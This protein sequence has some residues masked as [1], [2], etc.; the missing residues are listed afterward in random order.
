MHPLS[1]NIKCKFTIPFYSIKELSVVHDMRSL[2]KTIIILFFLL[3]YYFAFSQS[4]INHF[5]HFT[6]DHGLPQN[7]V[8]SMCFDQ[9][10]KII[11]QTEGGVATYDGK[12]IK[13]LHI[14]KKSPRN[15]N[16]VKIGSEVYIIDHGQHLYSI[17]NDSLKNEG[18]TIVNYGAYNSYSLESAIKRYSINKINKLENRLDY[19]YHF[20][21]ISDSLKYTKTNMGIIGFSESHVYSIDNTGTLSII[22]R[23]EWPNNK[24]KRNIITRGNFFFDEKYSFVIIDSSIYNISHSHDGIVFDKI[25]IELPNEI[26]KNTITTAIFEDITQ[27]FFIGTLSNGFYAIKKPH[28]TS[29]QTSN[30]YLERNIFYSQVYHN[31]HIYTANGTIF[32]LS[33]FKILEAKK[34]ISSFSSIY[35]DF[36]NNIWQTNDSKLSITKDNKVIKKFEHYIGAKI[37]H[38]IRQDSTLFIANGNKFHNFTYDSSN[39]ELNEEFDY[40]FD[41]SQTIEQMYLLGDSIYI[42]TQKGMYIYDRI[43]SSIRVSELPEK[44]Y[45]GIYPSSKGIEYVTTYGD[46]LYVKQDNI[47][48]PLPFD[49]AKYMDY[50]HYIIADTLGYLWIPTNN[51]LYQVMEREVEDY[52]VGKIKNITY[53]YYDKTYGLPRNEFNGGIQNCGIQ[54][55][56]GVI[57]MSNMNG[58]ALFD[59]TQIKADFPSNNIY[60]SCVDVDGQKVAYTD[61]ISVSENFEYTNITVGSSY[62]GLDANFHLEYK[63]ST[64]D[65]EWH[66]I[67]TQR[68]ISILN[69]TPGLQQIDIRLRSGFGSEDYIYKTIY[70][71][72]PPKYYQTLLFK[73]AVGLGVIIFS[74]LII[75][76]YKLYTKNKVL[77]LQKKIEEHTVVLRETNI[78]LQRSLNLSET[79]KTALVHDIKTPLNTCVTTLSDLL[80]IWNEISD[81]IKTNTLTTIYGFQKKLSL[82]INQYLN[83]VTYQHNTDIQQSNINLHDL[84]HKIIQLFSIEKK[85]AKNKITLDNTI[86]KNINIKTNDTLLKIIMSNI[87]ENA[88]KYTTQGAIAISASENRSLN[89]VE[90]TCRDEGKGM[91]NIEIKKLLQK[92]I[93]INRNIQSGYNLGYLLINHSLELLEGKLSIQSDGVSYTEV[94]IELY[95][96]SRR[97]VI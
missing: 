90:I 88:I 26:I 9:N 33:N 47:L 94:K 86:P 23:V 20:P 31:D 61:T 15:L 83:V 17:S 44:Y 32:N 56:N 3:H 64:I 91:S 87:I 55:P 2:Q 18:I 67:S 12:S 25:S 74:M 97:E 95:D 43:N 72:I 53:F 21:A 68:E 65:K 59:P 54:M 42:S 38:L 8:I 48:V 46:G 49:K 78:Q 70:I 73:I 11:L 19:K 40:E 82:F 35:L 10:Q 34:N 60:V 57:S 51:G 39:H 29:L 37:K 22:D 13:T 16:T 63:I 30:E 41:F 50:P 66:D 89:L 75:Y 96:N 58:I 80:T 14:N 4:Y 76:L 92:E 93:S 85:V 27:S 45:R 1:P 81:D 62:Y 52:L 69:R 71:D 28:F 24:V 79:I 5:E 7:S 77:S 84:T 36:K 6:T